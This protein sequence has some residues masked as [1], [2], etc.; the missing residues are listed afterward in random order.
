[1]DPQSVQTAVTAS[2]LVSFIAMELARGRFFPRQASREDNR[3]DVAVTLLFPL[4]SLGVLAA[5]TGL[6]SVLIPDYQG[7]L[8]DWP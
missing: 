8:A 3:L 4:I 6:A 7:A 5:S 2:V 1:M